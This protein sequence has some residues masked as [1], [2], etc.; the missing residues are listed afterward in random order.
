MV[1]CA[2]K[3]DTRGFYQAVMKFTD[4]G[5]SATKNPVLMQVVLG[6][7]P[8]I[9]RLQYLAILINHTESFKNSSRY[10]KDIIDALD[11][12]DPDR[13]VKAIQDYIESEKN[14][15]LAAVETSELSMYL[16]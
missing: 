10:F 3:A 9:R 2:D 1:E 11:K 13:G 4:S 8:N 14:F 5:I 15:A 16:A 7:M 12:R 6:I